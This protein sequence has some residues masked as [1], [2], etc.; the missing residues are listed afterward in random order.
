L[1]D[2]L[3]RWRRDGNAEAALALLGAHEHHFVNGA[4][5][6]EAKVARAEILLVLGRSDQALVVLDS[7]SVA[8]LPRARELQTLR[9]ELRSQAGR[10]REAR[11][12]LSRV[13]ID[14]TADDL[15]RRASL[16]L[17]KCP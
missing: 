1:A 3:A 6:V 13:V 7:L 5:S 11:A 8:S 17:A 15:G 4:L 16:A 10:C 2:A 14:T 12:D 9:G